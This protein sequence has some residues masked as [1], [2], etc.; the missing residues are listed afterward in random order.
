MDGEKPSYEEMETR[1]AEAEA[2][3]EAI[4][5]D[6][7]DA[8]I[9]EHGVY[10]LRLH[11]VEKALR[12]SEARMR[13][14]LRAA[15]IGIG[16]VSNRII[17]EV[18]ER[19][20]ELSGYSRG[21]LIG[22]S[23]EVVYPTDEDYEYVGREKYRQIE[24]FGTGAVE[25][26]F[27]RKNGTVIDVFLSSTPLDS[28]DLSSGVTFTALDITERK[29]A[30]EAL[31]AERKRLEIILQQLPEGVIISEAQSG[32]LIYHNAQ[33]EKIWRHD[34][35][36][37]QSIDQYGLYKGFHPDGSPY[38]PEDWPLARTIATGEIVESEEIKFQRGDGSFGWMS[39][40]AAPIR[41]EKH[42]VIAVAVTFSDI[43][44]QKKIEETLRENNR[45][46]AEYS[47][48]LTHNLKEPLRAIHN[49]VDFLLE[50]LA[51]TL[52]GESK[53]YLEGIRKSIIKSSKQ[54]QD[55]ESLYGIK[56]HTV[57]FEKFDMR[58]LADEMQFMFK[59][60]LGSQIVAHENWPVV[61]GEKHLLR[62]ILINLISN[63][64]KYNRADLKRI[65]VGWQ[66]AAENRIEI[67]VRDN[68]IGIQPQF[69]EEIF[70]VFKRLHSD[71]EYKGT[72]IGLAIVRRAAQKIGG[73]L[74]VE[75]AVG[76][77]ST[78]YLGL[79]ESIVDRTYS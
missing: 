17:E 6:S 4:S 75:S 78:F 72:G 1:L 7:V 47:Y 40:S 69:Q 19:F 65:E 33:V 38:R 60:T 29:R 28:N 71:N 5:N 59:D 58:E 2:M 21:E 55:L 52:E 39:A 26:R 9:G 54:F 61:M 77:G 23:A 64:F 73:S 57:N 49:Y 31:K 50:D 34:F 20:C 66:E 79:P 41:D 68:G 13:S 11:E 10:L 18:N 43:T 44:E 67:F 74:R 35:V 25:T 70:G 53:R 16:V 37:S 24:K 76:V 42:T 51:D 22:K 15:P 62:Q 3:L 63:G 45:E 46:L 48:A 56:N 8:V 27:Q 36:E 30:Q 32:K 12:Q 14:I